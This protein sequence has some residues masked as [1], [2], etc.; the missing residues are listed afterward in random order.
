MPAG[1]PAPFDVSPPIDRYQAASRPSHLLLFFF[2]S[3][4]SRFSESANPQR[5]G[6]SSADSRAQSLFQSFIF[7]R[8]FQGS[9]MLRA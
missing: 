2:S 9:H 8:G 6:V 1:R 4:P 7:W 3:S 5:V